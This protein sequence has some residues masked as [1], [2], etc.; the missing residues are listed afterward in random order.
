MIQLIK[1]KTN[2]ISISFRFHGTVKLHE[3][4]VS[5]LA[6]NKKETII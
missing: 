4:L 5:M 3:Y 2:I 6:A 1:N